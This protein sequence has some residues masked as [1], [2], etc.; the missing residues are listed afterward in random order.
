MP[1]SGAIRHIRDRMRRVQV[2]LRA[3]SHY[4]LVGSRYMLRHAQALAR[5]INA[6]SVVVLADAT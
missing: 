5:E 6:R 3:R 2:A 4:R 1:R